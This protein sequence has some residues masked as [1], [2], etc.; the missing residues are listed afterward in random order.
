MSYIYKMSEIQE[1]Q[2]KQKNS[3]I[4]DSFN[5]MCCVCSVKSAVYSDKTL[6]IHLIIAKTLSNN[7][8]IFFFTKLM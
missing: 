5:D 6:K 7:Y 4:T 1:K 2:A 8:L 3:D